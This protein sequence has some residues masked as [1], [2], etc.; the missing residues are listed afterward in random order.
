MNEEE[1]EEKEQK[2]LMMR[3]DKWTSLL[4]DCGFDY[5][6]KTWESGEGFSLICEIQD[7]DKHNL[8][9]DFWLSGRIEFS[10]KEKEERL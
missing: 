10:L 9:I 4:N 2:E 3:L 6:K 8:S 1:F 7:N 5:T